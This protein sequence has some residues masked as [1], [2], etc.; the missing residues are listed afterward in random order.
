VLRVD[1]G[2]IGVRRAL[3]PTRGDTLSYF[4]LEEFILA[5]AGIVLG[6][7]LARDRQ[8][9]YARVPGPA[10]ARLV[11]SDRGRDALNARSDRGAGPALRASL[12]PSAPAIRIT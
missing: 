6:M 11:P 8:S 3:G 4:Q 7:M 5:T 1:P 12:I 10:P 2:Q 9:A